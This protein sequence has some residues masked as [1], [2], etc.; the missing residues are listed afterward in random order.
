MRSFR[1]AP[2]SQPQQDDPVGSVQIVVVVKFVV[3]LV[4]LVPFLNAGLV[5]FIGRSKFSRCTSLGYDRMEEYSLFSVFC[6][7][8]LLNI[9]SR[10]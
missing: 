8:I 10:N 2:G 4:F 9:I 3:S 6:F 5:V 7:L 1:V